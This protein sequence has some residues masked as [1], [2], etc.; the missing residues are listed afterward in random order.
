MRLYRKP[1]VFV[2]YNHE[3]TYLLEKICKN[4]TEVGIEVVY[5][6]RVQAADLLDKTLKKL[7]KKADAVVAIGSRKFMKSKWCCREVSYAVESGKQYCP[8][9][10]PDKDGTPIKIPD[11]F[12]GLLPTVARE[13]T[14]V[15]IN[16]PDESKNWLPNFCRKL[17]RHRPYKP[18][19][20]VSFAIVVFLLIP[21][22]FAMA[23]RLSM[24]EGLER[25]LSSSKIR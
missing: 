15:E 14:Y 1:R 21:I 8:L 11:W 20:L 23:V 24:Q 2:S 16:N 9:V 6:E 12:K 19:W 13:V 5:D 17:Q 4:L 3:D 25:R 10:F 18:I 22:C 7:I